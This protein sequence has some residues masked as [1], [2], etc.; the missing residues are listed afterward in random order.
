MDEKGKVNVA[1]DLDPA[2]SKIAGPILDVSP[3]RGQVVYKSLLDGD[4]GLRVIDLESGAVTKVDTSDADWAIARFSPDSRRIAYSDLKSVRLY[5]CSSKTSLNIRS[6]MSEED[7]YGN[8]VYAF[9]GNI[10]WV[11]ATALYYEYLSAMPSSY[12]I[13]STDDPTIN[14]DRYAIVSVNGNIIR[15]GKSKEFDFFVH[16]DYLYF[17][18]YQ[19]GNGPEGI[20]TDVASFIKNDISRK[21]GQEKAF[22]DGWPT[23]FAPDEKHLIYVRQKNKGYAWN[24]HDV[25]SGRD[26]LL[27]ATLDLTKFVQGYLSDWSADSSYLFLFESRYVSDDGDFTTPH[28]Y[29]IPMTNKLPIDVELSEGLDD[30]SYVSFLWYAK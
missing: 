20:L 7:V 10:S 11:G 2:L 8:Q 29:A 17:V 24:W 13:G 22:S 25:V 27:G 4:K 3:D 21:E 5:D 18:R 23:F 15:G 26:T 9:A 6:R 12:T 19:S 14:S 28:L 1:E 30:F 16:D